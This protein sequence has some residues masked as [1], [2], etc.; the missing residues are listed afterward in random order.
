MRACVGQINPADLYRFLPEDAV[1]GAL[2]PQLFRAW[3]SRSTTDVLALGQGH[4]AD[5]GGRLVHG[6]VLLGLVGQ[7]VERNGCIISLP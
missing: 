2:L 3:C 4:A 5:V 7:L 6:G 1:P